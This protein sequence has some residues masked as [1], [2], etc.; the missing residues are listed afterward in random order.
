MAS[1]Q[2]FE[3]DLQQNNFAINARIN[4]YD[5]DRYNLL[6]ER[7]RVEIS[8]ESKSMSFHDSKWEI[9]RVVSPM[10]KPGKYKV[11]ITFKCLSGEVKDASLSVDFDFLNL[12]KKNYVLLP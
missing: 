12:E 4:H 8:D 2:T 11:N 6:V 1:G 9:T 7:N 3:T 10:E 5:T